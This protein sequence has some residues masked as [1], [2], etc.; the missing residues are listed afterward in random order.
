MCEFMMQQM[1]AAEEQRDAAANSEG[2]V[3]TEFKREI[4]QTVRRS[5]LKVYA[6]RER[7]GKYDEPTQ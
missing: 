3:D 1:Q 6:K 5:F 2:K 7:G 4:Y